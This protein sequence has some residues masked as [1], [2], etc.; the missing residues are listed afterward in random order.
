MNISV[1]KA[2]SPKEA[3]RELAGYFDILRQRVF[4]AHKNNPAT[5]Q[6][7]SVHEANV[8]LSLGTRGKLTMSEIADVLQLSLSS[9]TA[10]ID[11]LEEKNCVRRDRSEE[12]RRIVHVVLTGQGKKF[13]DLVERS[14]MNLTLEML[15]ALDPEEQ[16]ELLRLFR[17]ITSRFEQA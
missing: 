3:A 15:A 8:L 9:V 12:D 4:A 11:K 7:I 5:N 13:Y 6:A 14:H 17:K 1:S 10:I 2:I 16:G